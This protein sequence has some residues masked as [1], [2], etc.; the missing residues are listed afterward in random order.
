MVASRLIEQTFV[1]EFHDRIEVLPML[2][3]DVTAK[4]LGPFIAGE[5]PRPIGI[6]PGYSSNGNLVVLAI[7]SASHVLV[8]QFHSTKVKR[9]SGI[10]EGASNRIKSRV[11]L[12]RKLLEEILLCRPVGNIFAFDLGPLALALYMDHNVRI[13]NGVDLQSACPVKSRLPLHSIKFA[14]GDKI[15]IFSDNISAAFDEMGYDPKRMT[16]LAMR[17]WV[18]QYLPTVPGMED[19]IEKVR[20]I[21]TMT[22]ADQVSLLCS[23]LTTYT[24]LAIYMTR[25]ISI[26]LPSLPVILCVWIR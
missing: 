23:R 20:K 7:A 17:A 4:T 1:D 9:D 15:D 2:E 11:T 14:V 25:S 8:V 22:M 13:V 5:L 18:S 21:N 16:E 24:N 19:R 3:S 10:Q 26:S 6:S 12:G